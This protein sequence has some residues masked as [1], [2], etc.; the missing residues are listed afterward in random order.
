M[1]LSVIQ[2]LGGNNNNDNN[3]DDSN[4]NSPCLLISYHVLVSV[5]GDGAV[6][7]DATHFC[8]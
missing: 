3:Y 7:M 8:S 2:L 4:N 1:L 5:L 6:K